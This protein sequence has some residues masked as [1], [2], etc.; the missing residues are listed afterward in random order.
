MRSL[1]A[2]FLL[3]P[4]AIIVGALVLF[5]ARG[6]QTGSAFTL[7]VGDCFSMPAGATV[8]DV[9]VQ[10]CTTAHDGEVFYTQDDATTP[11][12]PGVEEF[13]KRVAAQCVDQAFA[14]YIGAPYGS[15]P[16]LKVAYF[17]PPA[18]AWASG[19]RRLTCYVAMSDGSKASES[20]RAKP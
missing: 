12:W 15:R 19:Q 5:T 11:V 13:S 18:D 2:G 14:P 3:V 7:Q 10:P 16:D 6:P 9:D 17:F 20:L 8:A 4:V 1:H